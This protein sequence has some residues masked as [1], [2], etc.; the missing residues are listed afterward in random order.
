MLNPRGYADK[1]Q[2]KGFAKY[3]VCGATTFVRTTLGKMTFSGL[4]AAGQ[5]VDCQWHSGVYRF[6]ECHF[7]KCYSSESHFA[8]CHPADY[9]AE[10]NSAKCHYAECPS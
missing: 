9:F 10:C 4:L 1:V 5:Q 8:E 6:D 7:A 3:T 2:F